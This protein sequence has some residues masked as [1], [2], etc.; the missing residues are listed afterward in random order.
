MTDAPPPRPP[1]AQAPSS[2]FS[3]ARPGWEPIPVVVQDAERKR[4]TRLYAMLLTEYAVV[5]AVAEILL[6][7]ANQSGDGTLAL[8]GLVLDVF[9]VV[10]LPIEASRFA[11]TDAPFASFLGALMLPP[12]LRAVTLS[13]PVSLF[14]QTEWL[15]VVS[16]PLLLAVASMM[17]ALRLRPQDIFLGIGRRQL[18]AV[19]VTF[20]AAGAA[21]GFAEFRL[22]HP[23]AWVDALGSSQL[24]FAGIAVF[25]ATGLAE[26]LIFRGLL[27]RTGTRFLGTRAGLV[28]VTVVF[29]ILN[30]GFLSLPD[31]ALVFV[32][33]LVAGIVVL[34][35]RCVWGA[36]FA[37]TI[38]NVLLYLVLPFGL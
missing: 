20:A 10:S 3:I 9:L 36:V 27:L 6:A 5:L 33:G 34:V 18:L 4:R 7:L 22:L 16:V 38:A 24:A 25:L 23:Q 21:F 29:A 2:P 28:Y 26:E 32:F 31:L 13:T 19:N 8:I 15:L 11:A 1:A 14:T 30:A 12:M 37:H 35:T 17:R